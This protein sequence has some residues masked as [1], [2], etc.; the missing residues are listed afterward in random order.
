MNAVLEKTQRLLELLGHDE[1][2]YGVCYSDVKPEGFGPKP[3]EPG[4]GTR[5]NNG[6]G[7]GV[8]NLL[9]P[10]GQYLESQ[11]KTDCGVDK[12]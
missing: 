12:P 9:L 6:L 1:A 3:G 8:F 5:R 4:K 10:R 2:P 11:E 7:K